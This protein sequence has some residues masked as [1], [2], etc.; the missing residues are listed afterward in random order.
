MGLVLILIYIAAGAAANTYIRH[1][2]FGIQ[3]VYVFSWENFIMDK[4]IWAVLLGWISI[5][6]AIL[7]VLVLGKSK[8]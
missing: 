5:P 3:T 4:F 6:V 2:I 8:K 1:N 7:H